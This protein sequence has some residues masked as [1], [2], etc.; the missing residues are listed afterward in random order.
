MHTDIFISFTLYSFPLLVSSTQ[1]FYSV[2]NKKADLP[3]PG[4]G[5]KWV[6]FDPTGLERAAKAVKELDSSGEKLFQCCGKHFLFTSSFSSYHVMSSAHAR[7]AL[8]LAKM[9][10]TTSQLK[11][12]EEIQVSMVVMLWLTLIYLRGSI[13][14]L[15]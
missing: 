5:K 9:Q 11:Y 14:K 6:E 8:D 15:W 13:W 2:A 10:E 7:E 4:G 3:L 1:L 12:N